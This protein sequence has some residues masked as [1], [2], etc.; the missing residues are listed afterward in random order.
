MASVI[1]FTSGES[2]GVTADA[3]DVTDQIG[4]GKKF[5]PF[6]LAAIPMKIYVASH[7]VTYVQ[8]LHVEPPTD[9]TA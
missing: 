9:A 6:M 1:H 8:D 7:A 5:T 4:K 3:K 2:V